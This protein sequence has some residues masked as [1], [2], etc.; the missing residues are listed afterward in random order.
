MPQALLR[1]CLRQFRPA[2]DTRAAVGK[3]TLGRILPALLNSNQTRDPLSSFFYEERTAGQH[4]QIAPRSREAALAPSKPPCA[5]LRKARPRL[6]REAPDATKP[7]LLPWPGFG[8]MLAQVR[9]SSRKDDCASHGSRVNELARYFN[10]TSVFL[11]T[12]AATARSPAPLRRSGARGGAGRA[13]RP[14][15]SAALPAPV[16][17]TPICLPPTHV[18]QNSRAR[19]AVPHLQHYLLGDRHADRRESRACW[20]MRV[21]AEGSQMPALKEVM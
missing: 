12:S 13:A 17:Q 2:E 18:A 7:P 14:G 15:S 1:R 21:L 4:R 9:Q 8:A 6:C 5:R 20:K 3:H 10:S 19:A 11:G 16:C